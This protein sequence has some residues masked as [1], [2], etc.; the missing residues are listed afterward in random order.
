MN[1]KLLL[2]IPLL[3]LTLT[4]CSRS[5]SS[6]SSSDSSSSSEDLPSSKLATFKFYLDYSN[7]EEEIYMMKWYIGVPLGTCPEEAELSD[8]D[9]SDPLYPN[10]LGYSRY[11][12][13]N[14]DSL[15]WDFATDVAEG[16]TAVLLYGIWSAQ[17]L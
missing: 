17:L 11:S 7:S 3:A 2:L 9:A 14:D 15:L 10:F 16:Q 5:D 4:G 6:S 12:S 8:E 1:K 13:S